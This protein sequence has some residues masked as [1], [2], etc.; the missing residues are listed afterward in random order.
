MPQWLYGVIG[1]AAGSGAL[2]LLAIVTKRANLYHR[3]YN[4]GVALRNIGLGF[5]IPVIGGDAEA[6]L[7]ERLLSTLSDIIRGLARGL[8]GKPE[9]ENGNTVPPTSPPSGG[10]D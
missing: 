4:W 5:D 6:T 3:L 9:Q 8:A 7:K 2:A 10:G 1:T